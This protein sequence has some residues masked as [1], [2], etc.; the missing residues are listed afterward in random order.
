MNTGNRELLLIFVDKMN[1]FSLS[2][3][4]LPR[5]G[6]NTKLNAYVFTHVLYA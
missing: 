1:M 4:K 5:S 6:K 2:G 3:L